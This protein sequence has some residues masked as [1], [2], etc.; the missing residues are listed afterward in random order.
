VTETPLDPFTPEGDRLATA[1][2]EGEVLWRTL[3]EMSDERDRG[4]LRALMT[5]EPDDV[6][7]VLYWLLADRATSRRARFRA[8]RRR[9]FATLRRRR[10]GDRP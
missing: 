7:A 2:R 3:T 4:T 8:W 6:V 5:M 10:K 1:I 9:L